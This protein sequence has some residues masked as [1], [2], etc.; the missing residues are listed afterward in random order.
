VERS[1]NIETEVLVEFTLLWL[2]WVLVSI[3]NV[4]L[5]VDL[6]VFVVNNNVSVFSINIALN[7][8]DLAFLVD[9]ESTF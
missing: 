9:N 4:P 3:D 2:L 8:K 6:S 5:L 7:I 1:L